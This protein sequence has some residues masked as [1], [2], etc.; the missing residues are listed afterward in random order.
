MPLQKKNTKLAETC[1]TKDQNNLA[2][3]KARFKGT[4]LLL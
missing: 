1:K 3:L 4:N 2:G